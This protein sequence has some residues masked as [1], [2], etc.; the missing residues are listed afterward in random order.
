MWRDATELDELSIYK[1]ML[2]MGVFDV[3]AVSCETIRKKERHS[4]PRL[5]FVYLQI[6]GFIDHML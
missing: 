2:S 1:L 6:I 3:H 4:I 5:C